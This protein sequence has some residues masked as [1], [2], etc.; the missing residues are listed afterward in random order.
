MGLYARAILPRL[1]HA[2]MRQELFLPYRQRLVREAEGRVLEIGFGS[3]LNMPHY[4]TTLAVIGLDPSH[5]ALSMA[6]NSAQTGLR[7]IGLLEASAETIPLARHSVDTIVSAWTMCSIPD[8]ARALG[9][10]RRVLKPSGRL[11][12]V[13]HGRS[14]DA[15][16]AKWQDRLTPIWKHVAGGCHLNR[17]VSALVEQAGFRIERLETGYM[18]GPRPLTFMYEGCARPR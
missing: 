14:P 10:V 3:G 2:G 16:V 4:A 5:L 11:L 18:T 9:E 1:I 12:F 17:A 6:R 13:E 7:S 8:V 15:S